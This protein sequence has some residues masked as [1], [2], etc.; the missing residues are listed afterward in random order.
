MTGSNAAMSLTEKAA[1]LYKGEALAPMVRASTT[2]LRTL[3]LEYGADFV[4]TEELVDR[5]LSDTIRVF[6]EETHTIDYIRDTAKLAPRVQR[7]LVRQGRP[8]LIFQVDRK[9]EAGK[10][11]CQI[12]SGEPEL[13]LEAAL[14]VIQDVDAFDIK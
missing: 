14:H 2:P 6:N 11:V 8:A 9:R 3:A 7:R 13:A 1:A 12:G 4:Y 5:S 10:L